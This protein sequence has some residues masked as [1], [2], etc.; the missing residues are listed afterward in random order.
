MVQKYQSPVRVYK[1]PFELVMAAYEKRFPTCHMIPVFLGSDIL[2]EYKSDDGAVYIVERRCRLNV[3]APYL[4]K[5]IVGVDYVHFRQKNSLDRRERTLKIDAN[6]ESFSS[7]IIV[8]ENCQY[9]VHPD[10]PDWTCFEQQ[11]SLDIKSFFGF[12][13]TVEKIAMK[14]YSS[15]IK[16]G[17][18]IIEYYINEILS[19]EGPM[20]PRWFP[21]DMSETEKERRMSEPKALPPVVPDENESKVM[22]TLRRPSTHPEEDAGSQ[23]DLELGATAANFGATAAVTT[24][25]LKEDAIAKTKIDTEY[26]ER[27]L[28]KL[29]PVQES[30]LIQLRKWLQE[31]HKEKVPKDTHILRFLIARDFNLDKTRE[32]LCHSLAWR[33]LHRIDR[34]LETYK[35]SHVM[36]KFYPGGWH[37]YDRDDRPL[38]ILRLGGM[39]VKG[40]IKAVGEEGILKHV[41]SVNEDGIKRAEKATKLKG[42]PV[43]ACTCIVDLEGLSMR[44]LWRPGI[45]ALLRI[46]ETVEANYPETMG[47]LLIVRAPRV[48]PVL[49][50]LINPF[51][52]ENT[53]KKFMI[54]GGNDYQG[55][56][57]L[58]D[59]IDQQFIPDFLGGDCYCGV[60]EGGLVPKSLYQAECREHEEDLAPEPPLFADSLYHTAYIVKDYPHELLIHV[61]E[62]GCVITWDFDI[63]KGDVVFTLL[64]C[65]KPICDEPHQHHVHGAVGGIGSTQYVDKR[66]V[67]GVDIS[68]VLAPSVCRDGDSV[69]GSHVASQPGS[70]LLQWKSFESSKSRAPHSFD[71]SLTG[72]KSKVMY[73]TELINSHDFRGSMS[74]LQSCQSSFSSLS[75]NTGQSGTQGSCPSR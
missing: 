26:I 31:T 65:R 15:N 14:Q 18:E 61:P 57:G 68:I 70:Y 25:D 37:Y 13:S 1:F 74:S 53:R 63:L 48:F 71:F 21:P 47:R 58:V 60:P 59:Y 50:T 33:K 45:R 9:T 64:R 41:L 46:I 75:I 23:S 22:A 44:H 39:D 66:W 35:M 16:K 42:H 20:P 43:S 62:R 12:E 49:W 19:E 17:K 36:E 7:R 3:D 56:G 52:D 6:N 4:L 67:V 27:F 32:M 28:G 40:L 38:Y 69:Q 30:R 11:A 72:H 73:Y 29:T 54:Y 8:K 10:N 2:S 55:P 5:K 51:I 24:S 34:L